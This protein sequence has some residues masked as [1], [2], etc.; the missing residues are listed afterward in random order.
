MSASFAKSSYSV[1]RSCHPPSAGRPVILFMSSVSSDAWMNSSETP[2]RSSR[3]VRSQY[4]LRSSSGRCGPLT[5]KSGNTIP[6]VA[7][8]SRTA[9]SARRR[10]QLL[11][12]HPDRQCELL[13]QLLIDRI[14]RR[15]R[16]L[17]H[18][19]ASTPM[20]ESR[21][22]TSMPWLM[23]RSSPFTINSLSCASSPAAQRAAASAVPTRRPH[24]GDGSQGAV[25]ETTLSA[26]S[27]K[28]IA[29]S[30]TSIFVRRWVS[31][32]SAHRAADHK[33]LRNAISAAF[34]ASDRSSPIT[35][36]G[37]GRDF[38]PTTRKPVGT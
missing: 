27:R 16:G 10:Q 1:P 24:V 25:A 31:A 23:P 2:G 26:S 33:V 12:G 7:N 13:G 3:I 21:C 17:Y 35:C 38:A 37:T 28:S 8:S 15:R 6:A 11:R 34:S 32:A 29:P 19:A 22:V 30:A 14:P 20:W 36:P 4:A 5:R 9:L 18:T